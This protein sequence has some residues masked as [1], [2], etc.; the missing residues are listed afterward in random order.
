[1][2]EDIEAGKTIWDRITSRFDDEYNP[3]ITLETLTN[4]ILKRLGGIIKSQMDTEFAKA[5]ITNLYNQLR[6]QGR[7]SI[8]F[9]LGL[10][11]EEKEYQTESPLKTTSADYQRGAK[12]FREYSPGNSPPQYPV[13]EPSATQRILQDIKPGE[14]K[15]A[16][17]KKVI[18]RKSSK[19]KDLLD[20][21]I[22]AGKIAGPLTLNA[23][24]QLKNENDINEFINNLSEGQ[25]TRE[26]LEN[27]QKINLTKLINEIKKQVNFDYLNNKD[28][29]ENIDT[30]KDRIL[31]DL[32]SN[33]P[34]KYLNQDDFE[35]G[36][37]L[38]RTTPL[39]TT[40]QQEELKKQAGYRE[41]GQEAFQQGQNILDLK[42][43]FQA[44]LN[45]AKSNE[46]FK[47][48]LKKLTKD[49]DIIM[50]F[51]NVFEKFK[52]LDEFEKEKANFVIWWNNVI[53]KNKPPTPMSPE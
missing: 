12:K 32:L 20:Q 51:E 15:T 49:D 38:D 21:I 31:N 3:S 6:S 52:H 43:E 33:Y 14:A 41:V 13:L 17:E 18:E 39:I 7:L 19:P 48:D 16:F 9:E 46:N 2:A 44:D 50:V 23:L 37:I 27:I 10:E 26:E 40:K 47:K 29:N 34:Y 5:Q 25:T 1:M 11:I 45:K 4:M 42:R 28:I 22:D 24:K 35:Q 8:P 36:F 53:N 30:R